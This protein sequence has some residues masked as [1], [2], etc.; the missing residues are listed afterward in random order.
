MNEEEGRANA[1]KIEVDSLK[2]SK[3]EVLHL[4]CKGRDAWNAKKSNRSGFKFCIKIF[5][6]ICARELWVNNESLIIACH[7]IWYKSPIIARVKAGF[8]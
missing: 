8:H 4:F 2:S 3:A 1:L 5:I 7:G 6:K